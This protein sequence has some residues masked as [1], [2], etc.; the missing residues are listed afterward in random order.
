MESF[1]AEVVDK[2]II[3]KDYVE[4]LLD[5]KKPFD[6]VPGQYVILMDNIEGQ[7]V[8]R[9]YS[10]ASPP[11]LA[12]KENI[13]RLLIKKKENG[14]YSV[15]VYDKMQKGRKIKVMG[16][17]GNMLLSNASTKNYYFIASGSGIAP[18]IS[19]IYHLIEIKDYNKI[20]LIY[21]E[22]SK[23][24]LPYEE[25][26]RSLPITY[27]PVLSREE[28]EGYFHGHVQDILP[29]YIDGEGSYFICGMPKMVEEVESILKG[30][31]SYITHESY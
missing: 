15:F 4:L 23:E 11:T 29:N 1:E 19:M 14:F 22:K 3:A 21:G 8:S 2:K 18:F 6:F 13:I 26:F 9:A 28:R 20:V 16:P 7:I 30:K 10:I 25:E 12:L 17:A 31:V 24:Y 5:L 27:V